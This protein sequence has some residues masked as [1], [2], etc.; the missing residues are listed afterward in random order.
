VIHVSHVKLHRIK[1][2]GVEFEVTESRV[3]ISKAKKRGNSFY[4]L[5]PM[6][7]AKEL[8]IN[9]GDYVVMVMSKIVNV[10]LIPKEVK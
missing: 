2:G 3:V 7:K 10:D 8:S 1:V 5:I 4:V 6:E 9:D